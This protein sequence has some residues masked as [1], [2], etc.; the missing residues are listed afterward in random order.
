VALQLALQL[1][2]MSVPS[3]G[4]YDDILTILAQRGMYGPGCREDI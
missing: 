2:N 4:V 1:D 3:R